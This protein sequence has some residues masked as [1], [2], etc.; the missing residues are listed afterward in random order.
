MIT[1]KVT[2][3]QQVITMLRDITPSV[4][5]KLVNCMNRIT[6]DLQS[7]VVKT[8]LSGQVLK[9]RTGTLAASIQP[10]VVVTTVGVTGVVG[11]RVNES[12]PLKYAHIHEYGFTGTVTVKQ[13]LRMMTTA[14]GRPVKDP[15]QITISQ[16]S[17]VRNVPEKRYLRGTLEENRER[18]L[19]MINK[20][21]G[22]GIKRES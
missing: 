9:R 10:K 11:S 19:E 16:H 21:V 2:G 15:H 12:M 5:D 17:A 6:I 18:Y 7:Q 3:E 13:H 14:F 1:W 22:G 4:K 20:A 8:K